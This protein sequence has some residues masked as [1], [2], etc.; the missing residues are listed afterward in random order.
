MLT[1]TV[2]LFFLFGA[3]AAVINHVLDSTSHLF[4]IILAAG[5]VGH[6]T[7]APSKT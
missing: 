7:S 4:S 2:L 3:E 5:Q 1:L 6:G